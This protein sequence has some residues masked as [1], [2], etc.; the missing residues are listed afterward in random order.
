MHRGK[1]HMQDMTIEQFLEELASRQATPG[2]GSVAA[3]MGSMGAALVSMVCQLTLGKKG[4]ETSQD[5]IH[6]L[7]GDAESLR[8]SLMAAIQED[9]QSFTAVMMAYAMPKGTEEEQS[10]RSGHI[11][12]ALVAATDVPLH[13]AGLCL[14]VINLSHTAAVHGNRNVLSDAG[15]AAAAAEAAL[16]SAALNVRVNANMVRDRAFANAR[17]QAIEQLLEEGIP[18]AQRVYQWVQEHL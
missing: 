1:C 18:Q 15:V 11:Q 8:L 9:V 4:Y 3:L 7:L 17:I 10:V 14:Q 6:S 2:G 12:Q 13:C 16:K 5:T